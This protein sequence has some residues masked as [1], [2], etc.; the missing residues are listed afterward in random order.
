MTSFRIV[1]LGTRMRT[2]SFA[3]SLAGLHLYNVQGV[4]LFNPNSRI[5]KAKQAHKETKDVMLV[6]GEKKGK[7]K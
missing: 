2:R 7:T 4:S 3:S 1:A 5:P 6:R